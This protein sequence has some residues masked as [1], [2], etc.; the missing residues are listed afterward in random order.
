MIKRIG[1]IMNL[2]LAAVALLLGY[3]FMRSNIAADL[4]RDRLREAVKENEALRQTFNE[5]VKKTIVTELIVNDDDSVCVVFVSA[6]NTER[7]VPT[8][9]KKGAEVF[10]DFIVRDGKLFLRRVFDENTKPREAL[11]IDP[12]MQT[13]DWKSN[14]GPRGA[15]TYAQLNQ[16]GR[17]N[18]SVAGNGALELKKADDKAPRQGPVAMP[19]VKEFSVI[20]KELNTKVDDIGPGDVVRTLFGTEK[21]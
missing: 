5:A 12:D 18:V 2:A 20:E 19:P 4:Y 11:Y 8:P 7:V 9:F 16:N 17:W 10:V 14:G 13:V 1:I 3:H 21:K 15:A 6:D